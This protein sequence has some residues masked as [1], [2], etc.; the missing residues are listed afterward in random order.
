M[1]SQ[2]LLPSVVHQI[3]YVSIN[4]IKYKITYMTIKT[5]IKHDSGNV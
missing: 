3:I 2:T 4:D 1:T 5:K